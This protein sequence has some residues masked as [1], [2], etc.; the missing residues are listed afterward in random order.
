[1]LRRRPLPSAL[2]ARASLAAA[3]LMLVASVP[4]GSWAAPSASAA[5]DDG[6][7]PLQMEITELTPSVP[8]ADDLVQISGTVTNSSR[9]VWTTINVHAFHSLTP[10]LDS[11]TLALAA[12]M[13]EE[14]V[15]GPRIV[16]P[17]TFQTIPQLAPGESAEFTV[18]VPPGSLAGGD[19]VY[20]AGVHAIGQTETQVRD[21]SADGR[22][23]TF[24]PVVT[25]RRPRLDAAVILP[26]RAPIQHTPAGRI[27]RPA[28]WAK[29]LGPGGRLRN[30]LEAGQAA[31]DRPVT[32][33]L[34]PAV[35]H[36]VMKLA[37]GNPPASTAPLPDATAE[38]GGDDSGDGSEGETDDSGGAAGTDGETPA[39]PP[40]DPTQSVPEPEDGEPAKEP[41]PQ[42]VAAAAA[43]QGWLELFKAEMSQHP[44]LAL[45]YGDVDASALQERA[46]ELLALARTH[47]DQV[48]AELGIS[49]TPVLAPPDGWLSPEAIAA[50]TP[51]TGILL[52]DRALQ[53]PLGQT[54][55]T[56]RILDRTFATSSSGIA[57][58]GPG[59]E[60][61]SGAIAVR[62]RVVS[63]AALQML[64]DDRSPLVIAPPPS[65]DPATG[66]EQLYSTFVRGLLKLRPLSDV[67]GAEALT[68][69]LSSPAPGQSLPDDALVWTDAQRE[70]LLPGASISVVEEQLER[71]RLLEGVLSRPSP[72]VS[73]VLEAALPSLSYF[74]R[75]DAGTWRQRTVRATD[76]LDDRLESIRIETPLRATLSSDRG[77][78]GV[79]I[80]N[81][82]DVSV[83]VRIAASSPGG[84]LIEEQEPLTLAPQSRRRMRLQAT[85]T[86]EGKQELTL[87][88]TDQEGVP[89]GSVASYPVRTSQV[90]GI[91]WVIMGAGAALLFGA[92]GVRLARG[93]RATRREQ[94]EELEEPGE[95]GERGEPDEP[96]TQDPAPEPETQE[97]R[98]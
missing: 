69:P 3:L 85:A 56:G 68:A 75:R 90:S 66:S 20:W 76:W 46:P 82:L 87:R 40:T 34:D 95:P 11:P 6:A 33:L 44:V 38:E 74:A 42:Q 26:L 48:L 57:A 15:L 77:T 80:V 43:A 4:L 13:P 83:T 10:I 7:D 17:G 51:E 53:D 18:L 78:L 1:M 63:E 21:G 27:A 94:A 61:A 29:L 81:D 12:T 98:G 19:G 16:D 2:R 96:E 89:L 9:E 45:P 93:N 58:G 31:G 55:S 52:S 41:S 59:P 36:A 70:A 92:I 71:A 65:W 91:L 64:V 22:A 32:W 86:R 79:T 54:P 14:E 73:S 67:I 24:L 35:P 47:S 62:Q 97:A 49:A 39:P 84:L 50:T 5:P 25:D 60:R 30:L 28:A 72:L 37:A 88:V 23:R 8:A